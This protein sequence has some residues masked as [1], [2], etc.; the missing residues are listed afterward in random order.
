MVEV[1]VSVCMGLTALLE[2]QRQ[3]LQLPLALP[4]RLL[5]AEE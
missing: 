3:T 4:V 2:Q 5:E 1:A